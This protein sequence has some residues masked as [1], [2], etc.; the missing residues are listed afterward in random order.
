VQ[1]AAMVTTPA[2]SARTRLSIESIHHRPGDR[3]VHAG[4]MMMFA[5]MRSRVT[6]VVCS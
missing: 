4:C 5:T 2:S 6:P 3:R 1:G